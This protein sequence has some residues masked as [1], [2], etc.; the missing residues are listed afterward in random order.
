[1]R[2][3]PELPRSTGAELWPCVGRGASYECDGPRLAACAAGVPAVIARCRTGAAACVGAS[4]GPA[5]RPRM[6]SIPP[7]PPSMRSVG[8]GVLDAPLPP[9]RLASLK[10]ALDGA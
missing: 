2:K 5:A 4:I 9:I 7:P 6:S 10:L 3:V 1:M 8:G